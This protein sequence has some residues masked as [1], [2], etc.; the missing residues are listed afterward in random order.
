MYIYVFY[1]VQYRLLIHTLKHK[2][3]TEIIIDNNKRD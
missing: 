1:N 3:V 2:I